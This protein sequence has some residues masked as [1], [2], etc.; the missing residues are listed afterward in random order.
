MGF[1]TLQNGTKRH[2]FALFY[3][4]YTVLKKIALKPWYK[5]SRKFLK[6]SPKE[7]NYNR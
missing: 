2:I 1:K 4:F 6:E 7:G 5:T 3:A